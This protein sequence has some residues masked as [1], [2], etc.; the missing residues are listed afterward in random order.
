MSEDN[1]CPDCWEPTDATV[2]TVYDY[3][4]LDGYKLSLNIIDEEIL[5]VSLVARGRAGMLVVIIDDPSD[6]Y[7]LAENITA[8]AKAQVNP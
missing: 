1:V 7:K 5:A 4:D 6:A 3:I 8:W 2:V